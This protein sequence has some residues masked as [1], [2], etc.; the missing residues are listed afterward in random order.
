MET[1]IEKQRESGVEG[2]IARECLLFLVFILLE[3][4][5]EASVNKAEAA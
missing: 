3:K 5:K 4:V 2:V 1:S